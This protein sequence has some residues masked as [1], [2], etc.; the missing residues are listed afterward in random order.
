MDI[1]TSGFVN[2]FV[3]VETYRNYFLATEI[4][5]ESRKQHYQ[6]R[7]K[8]VEEVLEVSECMKQSSYRGRKN[9]R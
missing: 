3:V 7:V 6:L 9:T 4:S 5:Q 8:N 1:D 2:T